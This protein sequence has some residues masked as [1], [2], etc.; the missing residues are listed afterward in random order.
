MTKF[1][2]D[3]IAEQRHFLLRR[4]H[5]LMGLVFGAYI[6]MHLFVNATG[7]WPKAYQQNVD[8]IHSLEPMLP[9]IEIGAIFVPMLL[10]AIYGIY[11]TK[12]GVKY[13]MMKYNYG[14]NIRYTMQRWAGVILVLFVAYHIA[15]LHKWG[16]ALLG[17]QGF[18]KFDAQNMAYQSTVRAVRSPYRSQL[19][20]IAVIF[21]YLLGTWSA[22]FHWANGLWT[23]AIAWGLTTTAASQKRW[24]HVCCGFGIVMLVL[25]TTAWAAFAIVGNPDLPVSQ[26]TT[27][28]LGQAQMN[29]VNGHR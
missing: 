4:I 10:H 9:L 6:T 18:P 3:T 7:L 15:T 24:G 5:S 27:S 25:G 1:G 12:A 28:G 8:H 17:V 21:F 22:V 16:L 23:A 29:D 2:F 19:A 11:I 14:G 20:N 13:N 26:T